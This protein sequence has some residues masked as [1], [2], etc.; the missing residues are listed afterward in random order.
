MVDL[1]PRANGAQASL[2]NSLEKEIVAWP[3]HAGG[4]KG[5]DKGFLSLAFPHVGH[6]LTR[7]SE[8]DPLGGI[9]SQVAVAVIYKFANHQAGVGG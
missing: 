2:D 7:E 5:P 8:A 4:K 3:G 6:A 9:G 1:G